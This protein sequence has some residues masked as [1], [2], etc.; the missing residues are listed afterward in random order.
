MKLSANCLKNAQE[1][2]MKI[3]KFFF[4]FT[5]KLV[6]KILMLELTDALERRSATISQIV[7]KDAPMPYPCR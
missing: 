4:E 5:R 1:Y 2:Q 6:W 3:A 7:H